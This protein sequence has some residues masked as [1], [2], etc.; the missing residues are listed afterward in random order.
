MVKAPEE[1]FFFVAFC[2]WLLKAGNPLTCTVLQSTEI[3][4]YYLH[5]I[6]KSITFSCFESAVD[7]FLSVIFPSYDFSS[8][9]MPSLNTLPVIL[10]TFLFQSIFAFFFFFVGRWTEITGTIWN[11]QGVQYFLWCSLFFF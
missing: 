4:R 5:I 6:C 7:N 1:L 3:H 8:I 11:T 2:N 10:Y 9:P